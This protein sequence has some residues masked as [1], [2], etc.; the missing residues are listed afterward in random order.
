MT[1]LGL[2]FRFSKMREDHGE[3]TGM[4]R[5]YSVD[6]PG[7][8]D[9]N[10]SNGK[11]ILVGPRS[12][13]DVIKAC[14][15]RCASFPDWADLVDDACEYMLALMSSGEPFVDL[16]EGDIEAD[17]PFVLH[18][19]MRADE[20]ALLFGSGG[21]GKSTLALAVAMGLTADPSC[22][23]DGLWGFTP[24]A[25]PQRVGYLDYEDAESNFKR[26][27]RALSAGAG[28]PTPR[29]M[30]KRGEAS[31]SLSAEALGRQCADL[32]LTGLVIDSAGLACGAEPERAESA[33]AYFRALRAL[34]L[35]WSLT[36]AHQPKDKEN[37]NYPFGSVFW[38]NNPRMIWKLSGLPA[39]GGLGI[40]LEHRKSSNGELQERIG[41][42]FSYADGKATIE[43]RDP[44]KIVGLS[45]HMRHP[46]AIPETLRENGPMKPHQIAD[47][48]G[49]S[50]SGI[51]KLLERAVDAG[52]IRKG[53]SDLYEWVDTSEPE[54]QESIPFD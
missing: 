46:D 48:V 25:V 33:N 6:Y 43:R 11:V 14:R 8:P 2:H 36:I 29:V 18:P 7:L 28:I 4:L 10:L 15:D 35:S 42:L 40:G 53:R 47:R 5:V 52:K 45:E 31:L 32:G 24:T 41:L 13:A 37:S 22:W 44:R 50:R 27:L 34:P 17:A 1:D 16:S 12:K 30:Y 19:L 23:A 38:W 51:Y 20:H 39:N 26:R 54:D 49:L 3:E 21:S 9:R